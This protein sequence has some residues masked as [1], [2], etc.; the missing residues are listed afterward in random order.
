LGFAG[1]LNRDPPTLGLQLCIIHGGA[2]IGTDG[3]EFIRIIQRI[4]K[5]KTMEFENDII[6]N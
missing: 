5:H 4:C 3:P 2:L 6:Y 1:N